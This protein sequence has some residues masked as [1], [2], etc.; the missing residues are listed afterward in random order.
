MMSNE[1]EPT[2]GYLSDAEFEQLIK[3]APLISIDLIVHSDKG[4]LLVGKRK[5]EPAK[6]SYFVPGG[7]ILKEEKIPQALDRLTKEELGEN[8]KVES[9][10]FVGVYEHFYPSNFYEISG[11]G[12][13]YVVLAYEIKGRDYNF[14]QDGQHSEFKWMEI[15]SI[16]EDAK[17]HQYTKN[18]VN[19]RRIR[20]ESQYKDVAT[21]RNAHNAML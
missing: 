21:R 2:T 20:S 7:R 19:L 10:Q 8:S 6:G 5:N 4:E 1:P 18:Y 11:F 14:P 12:T 3:N 17:V 15:S 9:A 16:K 13:H